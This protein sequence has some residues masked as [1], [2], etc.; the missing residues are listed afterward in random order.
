MN[1]LRFCEL[2]SFAMCT[3]QGRCQAW[4][5][6][7]P[8]VTRCTTTRLWLLRSERTVLPWPSQVYHDFKT[9]CFQHSP[10]TERLPT[11]AFL[12]RRDHM[13]MHSRHQ[14]PCLPNR[15]GEGDGC[16]LPLCHTR[17]MYNHPL[18]GDRT[19]CT[20]SRRLLWRRMKRSRLC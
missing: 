7:C 1:V 18:I 11:R 10:F 6:V 9:W 15:A 3:E 8:T 13:A 2:F 16:E 5:C 20:W 17:A 14:R 4:R 12:V 19:R